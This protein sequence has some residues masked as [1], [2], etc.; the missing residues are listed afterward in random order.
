MDIK[1]IRDESIA[2]AKRLP[3]KYNRSNH[4]F[5]GVYVKYARNGDIEDVLIVE[6]KTE[7]GVSNITKGAPDT[8]EVRQ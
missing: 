4:G 3:T 6:V 8:R 1:R 2:A 7:S 5:D